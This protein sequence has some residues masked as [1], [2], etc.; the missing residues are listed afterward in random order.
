MDNVA[1]EASKTSEEFRDLK[2]KTSPAQTTSTGQPLTRTWNLDGVCVCVNQTE[3]TKMPDYHSLL[4][5]LLSV[6]PELPA[7]VAELTSAVGATA[8]H[9]HFLCWRGDLHPRCAIPT[10]STL[11]LQVLV[12]DSGM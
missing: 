9:R 4:Y 8:S 5:S 1:A 12:L 6:R 3:L 2:N 10:S 7:S 11:V